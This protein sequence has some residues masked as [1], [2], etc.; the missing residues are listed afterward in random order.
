MCDNDVFRLLSVLQSS[1][2]A[3]RR[4]PWYDGKKPKMIQ[5]ESSKYH[6]WIRGRE[7]QKRVKK[8]I[9]QD[10]GVFLVVHT[11][12]AVLRKVPDS[13]PGVW[14]Y[15]ITWHF[16]RERLAV[17]TC[18]GKRNTGTGFWSAYGEKYWKYKSVCWRQHESFWT[19]MTTGNANLVQG[20]D[21]DG[22]HYCSTNQRRKKVVTGFQQQ[23]ITP[24]SPTHLTQVRCVWL[25]GYAPYA[26]CSV[27]YTYTKEPSARPTVSL[28]NVQQWYNGVVLFFFFFFLIWCAPKPVKLAGCVL[29]NCFILQPAP[30]LLPPTHS[31]PPHPTPRLMPFPLRHGTGQ[32]LRSGEVFRSQTRCEK[33]LLP[34]VQKQISGLPCWDQVYVSVSPPA[35]TVCAVWRPRRREP[36]NAA[37][38]Y[39]YHKFWHLFCV[40]VE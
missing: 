2:E 40:W 3:S 11:W 31:T 24:G 25:C 32:P 14:R 12:D 20:G 22:C 17:E 27:I 39:F 13:N 16:W 37:K 19:V 38:K 10:D 36:F 33:A 1:S 26:C 30:P 23:C 9:N 35:S 6:H 8:T 4:S 7:I 28:Y 21:D 29:H 15:S 5:W 34:P 18:P